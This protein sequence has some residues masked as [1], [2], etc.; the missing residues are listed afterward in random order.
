M[1]RVFFKRKKGTNNLEKL[2]SRPFKKNYTEEDLHRFLEVEPSLI[3]RSASEGDSIPTIAVASH[4]KLDRG[5]LDLLLLDSEGD[6]TIVELKRDRTS[7]EIIGQLLDYA[8][9][10]S[11]LGFHGLSEY[12]VDWDEAIEL[13]SNLDN[14]SEKVDTDHI[15]LS[16]QNP[17]LLIVAFEIDEATKR[18][19]EFL[20]ERGVSIYC[21]EFKYFNDDEYEYYYPEIIGSE[22]TQRIS[23]KDETAAE[24][25]YRLIWTDLIE[26]FK[27]KKPRVIRCTGG[28]KSFLS[29]PIG[30]G[31]AHLEWNIHGLNKQNG[32]FE[33]GLHFEHR[34][35]DKNIQALQW[36]ES[37]RSQLESLIGEK[38]NFEEWGQ[39]WARIYARKEAPR[40]D[41]STK[42]WALDVMLRFYEAVD[43]LNVVS[44]LKKQGW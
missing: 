31:N 6:V 17:R 2:I 39:R 35:R 33:V 3:A 40:I 30:I 12:G 20:R 18:I 27:A 38:L 1:E 32:W 11:A 7:R 44:A 5:E 28:K 21:V 29:I 19:T 43:E 23:R 24:R 41:E 10:V 9:Q 16:L 15:K 26:K 34:D 8:A 36:L 22:T 42:N 25:E 13:L 14:A 4:L 37:Q